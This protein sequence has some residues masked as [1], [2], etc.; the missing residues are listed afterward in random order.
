MGRLFNGTA[1]APDDFSEEQETC[2]LYP[3]DATANLR[4]AE[5]RVSRRS[6]PFLFDRQ[7]TVRLPS[8]DQRQKRLRASRAGDHGGTSN[9]KQPQDGRSTE[10]SRITDRERRHRSLELTPSVADRQQTM[11]N[12]ELPIAGQPAAFRCHTM[13][14]IE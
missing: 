9:L 12:G 7:R 10:K 6:A 14:Y 1:T 13:L 11:K 2:D 8:A 4:P 5:C 3:F